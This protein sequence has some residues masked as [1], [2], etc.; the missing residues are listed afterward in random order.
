MSMNVENYDMNS[1]SNHQAEK[2]ELLI[3][4]KYV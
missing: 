1:S 2:R 3:Q 4:V